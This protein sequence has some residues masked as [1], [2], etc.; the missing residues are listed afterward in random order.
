[1]IV[2]FTVAITHHAPWFV[3]RCLDVDVASQGESVDEELV[4]L[5]EGLSLYLEGEELPDTLE[6]PVI[7]TFLLPA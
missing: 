4:N 2:K 1:L 6:P 5:K 3:A 7:T